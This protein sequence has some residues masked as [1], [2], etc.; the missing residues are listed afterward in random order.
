MAKPAQEV[1][2]GD[3]SAKMRDYL[4][5]IY[6]LGAYQTGENQFISTS[7]LADVLIVTPPA[8]NRM[9]ARLKEQGL[10]QHEPYQ[11]IR[12]TPAGRR[13]AL[14]RLRYHRIA[15]VFLVQVMGFQWHEIYEEARQMSSGMSDVLAA[16]MLEMAGNPSICPHG[17]PIPNPDGSIEGIDDELLASSEPGHPYQITRVLTRDPDRLSYMAALGLTPGNDIELI[18]VA[19]FNG[20]MQLKLHNEYRIIGHNLAELI[21]VK[22]AG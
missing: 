1:E 13:E 21:R 2:S 20:P 11:G 22:P 15:E 8:V 4:V 18:H 10:L 14:L 9:V 3:L 6:R 17:E 19:P 12:L 7:L 5:E 16:R